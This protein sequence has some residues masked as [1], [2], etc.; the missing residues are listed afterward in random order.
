MTRGLGPIRDLIRNQPREFK[1]PAPLAAGGLLAWSYHAASP[2]KRNAGLAMATEV[3]FK[4]ANN[5]T[6]SGTFEVHDDVVSVTT[7]TVAC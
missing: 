3:R 6:V 7:R 4:D 5:K 1:P 2:G